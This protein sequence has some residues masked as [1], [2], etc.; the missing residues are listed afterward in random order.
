METLPGLDSF[1]G[2]MA[3]LQ[4]QALGPLLEWAKAVVP[5]HRRHAVPLFLFATAGRPL[6]TS[7]CGGFCLG[8]LVRLPTYMGLGPCIASSTGASAYVRVQDVQLRL[9]F[10]S[11]H[12]SISIHLHPCS[13]IL[14]ATGVR[15]LPAE[16]QAV[17]MGD[18]RAVLRSSGFR[19]VAQ[20]PHVL[21]HAQ[22]AAVGAAPS[23]GGGSQLTCVLLLVQVPGRMGTDNQRN[24]RGRVRL[25]GH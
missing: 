3:E 13:Y 15:R 23:D 16:K 22:A 19:W 7:M 5:A 24:G 8:A 2:R 20:V 10:I 9:R 17:L 21:A 4:A 11:H 6:G 25:D 12:V 14:L 1:A 18:V